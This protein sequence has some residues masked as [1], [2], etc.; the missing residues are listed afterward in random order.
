LLQPE[1]L[2]KPPGRSPAF[3]AP[4]LAPLV[5]VFVAFGLNAPLSERTRR[6][7]H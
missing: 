4:F 7:R 6:E 2:S 1:L 3:H 5:E